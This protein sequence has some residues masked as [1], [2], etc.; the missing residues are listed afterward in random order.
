MNYTVKTM[1]QETTN[2]WIHTFHIWEQYNHLLPTYTFSLIC[3]FKHR[4]WEW[5]LLVTLLMFERVTTFD[6]LLS[7]N[8]QWLWVSN[9]TNRTLVCGYSMPGQHIDARMFHMDMV[10]L[11]KRLNDFIRLW[12]FWLCSLLLKD[13]VSPLPSKEEKWSTSSTSIYMYK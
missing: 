7:I 4:C 5:L 10:H 8:L 2:L 3:L 11:W 6:I 12:C 13:S 1:I 9:A